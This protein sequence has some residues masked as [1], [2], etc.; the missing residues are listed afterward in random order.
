MERRFISRLGPVVLLIA[1]VLFGTSVMAAPP[2][3]FDTRRGPAHSAPQTPHRVDPTPP[4]AR[5]APLP[6]QRFT[7][8]PPARPH[9]D[10]RSHGMARDY[11]RR[12]HAG[13]HCPPGLSRRG[14]SCVPN[15]ARSWILGR[16][17]PHQ[18]VYYDLP[19]R[20]LIRL[21]AVPP[22]YRYARVGGD[23]LMLAVGTGIVVDA[24]VD[25]FD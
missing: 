9:F 15:G 4:R 23:I 17:L 12:S 18:V 22:G 6:P 2:T 20:L 13:R 5:P 11:Y 7:R 21:P 14:A 25:V 24:M 8:R 10:D 1:S 3:G 19:A 16:P